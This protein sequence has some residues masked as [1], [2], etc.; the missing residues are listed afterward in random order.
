M[1]TKYT[2]QFFVIDPG[3]A[4]PAGTALTVQIFD[5][6]DQNDNGI[7]RGNTG[8]TANGGLI[9]QV[10]RNDTI[11]VT[12][13]GVTRTITG[14][15]FYISGQPAIFTPTDGTI[16][17]NATFISSTF[18]TTATQIPV[19]QFGPPCFTPGTLID[20][21]DGPRLI[22]DL[23]PGDLVSTRDRGAQVLLWMGSRTVPGTGRFAPV[24]FAQGAIGN[25][26][27]LVVSPQHRMLVDGWR[28]ELMFGEDA[29]L[30]PAK[31]LVNGRTIRQDPCEAVTYI[32]LLFENHEILTAHGVETESYFIGHLGSGDATET[33][34]EVLA[35]FPDLRAAVEELETVRPVVR[36]SDAAVLVA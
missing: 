11:R 4:P 28:A 6:F 22:E 33:R 8:D 9:T 21:P 17:S 35:L 24:T 26:D 27:V 20:T 18:V 31:A 5:F 12:M 32:H 36:A 29:V 19:T 15:T 2:D 10:W 3:S 14:V 16:L 25:T 30:V 34:A 23:R 1:P 13:G 7:I